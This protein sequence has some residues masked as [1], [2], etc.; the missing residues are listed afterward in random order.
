MSSTACAQVNKFSFFGD[1]VLG[2]T[3]CTE[4]FAVR[5]MP[6]AIFTI[7]PAFPFSPVG[8]GIAHRAK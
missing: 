7:Y 5:D 3:Y 8:P 6:T 2:E 1:L 4:K